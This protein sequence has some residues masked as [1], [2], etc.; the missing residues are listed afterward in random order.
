MQDRCHEKRVRQPQKLKKSPLDP[1]KR[2]RPRAKE[3]SQ[4]GE[5]DPPRTPGPPGQEGGSGSHQVEK[6]KKNRLPPPVKGKATAT[7]KEEESAPAHPG[8]G[9]GIPNPR[10]WK[11]CWKSR[12]PSAS[13]PAATGGHSPGSIHAVSPVKQAEERDIVRCAIGSTKETR[14]LPAENMTRTRKAE[15]R[16]SGGREKEKERVAGREERAA[17]RRIGK[18]TKET[19]RGGG[20]GSRERRGERSPEEEEVAP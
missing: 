19:S 15:T 13:S 7:E 20:P 1:K 5:G 9:T 17:P 4:R 3:R 14:P 11:M 8:E 6:K 2:T 12:P 10:K 18:G 16:T